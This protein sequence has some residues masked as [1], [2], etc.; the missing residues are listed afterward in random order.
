MRTKLL[1]LA[2]LAVQ[3]AHLLLGNQYYC[4]LFQFLK[5]YCLYNIENKLN[6][7]N[8]PYNKTLPSISFELY[9]F[10]STKIY[11][12]RI[13]FKSFHKFTIFWITSHFLSEPSLVWRSEL[14]ALHAGDS[15][16]QRGVSNKTNII[17]TRSHWDNYV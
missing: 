17:L 1:R 5:V 12:N 7:I 15:L 2:G 9:Y 6:I 10:F 4:V 8:T 13:P 14:K 3:G 16:W 11:M